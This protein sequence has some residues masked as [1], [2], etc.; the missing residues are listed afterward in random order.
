MNGAQRFG[1]LVV[2]CLLISLGACSL[3]HAGPDLVV[4]IP[5]GFG[6]S[7]SLEMGVKDAPPLPQQGKSYLVTVPRNGRVVTSTLLTNPQPIF[8][9]ASG[10][11][12]WGYSHSVSRTGDGIPI[13]GRIEFFVGTRK[14]Y[15]A[16]VNKR[17]H[18]RG[19][20]PTIDSSRPAS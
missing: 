17:S 16:E 11:E 5:P 4:Q 15:E 10:G 9:N 8:Q 2:L 12:V 3:R 13:G 18:S 7:F 1:A 20:G 14:D 6:G 19:A